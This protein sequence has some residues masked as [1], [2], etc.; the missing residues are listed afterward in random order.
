MSDTKI[1]DTQWIA[2]GVHSTLTE[3]KRSAYDE[4]RAGRVKYLRADI[5]EGIPRWVSVTE[6]LPE[7]EDSD[8]NN[9]VFVLVS[10]GSGTYLSWD[11]V[12]DY[13]EV[14]HWMPILQ[15]EG[16]L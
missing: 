16:G 1:P 11:D 9:N 6:R 2:P 10:D 5:H 12:R 8:V 13:P 3:P 4:P 7:Y 15:L 14:T